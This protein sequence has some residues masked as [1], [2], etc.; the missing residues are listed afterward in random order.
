MND[1][2]SDASAPP[3]SAT[4][5]HGST[6]HP[7]TAAGPV[8]RLEE[9]VS[10]WGGVDLDGR[11]VDV[12]HPQH[13]LLLAGTVLVM[14]SGRGSSSAAAVLAEQIRAGTAPAAVILGERDTILVAGALVAA[15]L[16]DVQV[17]VLTLPRPAYDRLAALAPADPTRAVTARVVGAAGSATVTLEGAR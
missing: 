6:L 12:H 14:P 15:E 9:P 11:V 5:L 7:G 1:A 2:G 13:G 4:S 17:P 3:A 16:Y 8:L 10:F